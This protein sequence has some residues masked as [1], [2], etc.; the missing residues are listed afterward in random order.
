MWQ[1]SVEE[2]MNTLKK[3][4]VDKKWA[5]LFYE[6]N[7]SFNVVRHPLFLDDVKSTSD[8][9][10]PYKPPS[11]HA[12]GT[13]LLKFAREE[14]ATMVTKKTKGPIHKYGVTICS[15]GWDDVTH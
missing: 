4:L 1:L 3:Q 6:A 2:G 8:S 12:M 7:I 5:T 9:R 13:K 10:V 15:N 11:Y 14:V